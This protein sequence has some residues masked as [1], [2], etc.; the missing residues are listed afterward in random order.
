LEISK[1]LALNCVIG[2]GGASHFELSECLNIHVKISKTE[3]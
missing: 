3:G 1:F 2:L